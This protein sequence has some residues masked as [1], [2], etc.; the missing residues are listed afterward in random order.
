[1]PDVD[2]VAGHYT[3][4]N[5]LDAILAGVERLGKSTDT[6]TVD[7]LVPVDEFHIGGRRATESLFEMVGIAPDD[8]VLDVGCGLGGASRFVAQRY[9]CRV[10][11][12]DLTQEYI[13]TG[14]A[15]CSWV[16]LADQI[17]LEQGNAMVLPY[18]DGAFDKAYM[19]HVGMNIANK[20]MLTAELYRIL[21]PWGVLAIYDVM[22]VSDGDLLFP[23]PWATTEEESA[24]STPEEYRDALRAAGFSVTVERNRHDFAMDFFAKLQTATAAAEGPPP[25]GLNVLMGETA[26]LKIKNMIAN[27]SQNIVAPVEIVSVKAG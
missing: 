8:H 11:G 1:M 2:M 20:Q 21:K 5:L 18:S 26:Q 13:E 14:N 19:L 6:V 4:G 7:D 23:V 27:I 12:I 15:L 16:G 24:V 25:L 22:R 3:Q 9:G 17:T 10:T